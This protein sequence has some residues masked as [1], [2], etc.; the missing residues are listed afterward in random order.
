MHLED[1]LDVLLEGQS[2]L[3]GWI[4]LQFLKLLGD[5]L[6]IAHE[7]LVPSEG[8]CHIATFG[9]RVFRSILMYSA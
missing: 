8:V 4:L 6:L 7:L 5:T 2:L 3:I 9:Y 1:I